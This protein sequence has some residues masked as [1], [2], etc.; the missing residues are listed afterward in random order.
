MEAGVLPTRNGGQKASVP[1]SPI[2][3]VRVSLGGEAFGRP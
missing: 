1:R 2:G 3:P